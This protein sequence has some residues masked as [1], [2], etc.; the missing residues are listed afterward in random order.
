MGTQLP[1]SKKG[2]QPPFFG[3]CLLW[4]NGWMDQDATWYGGRP[5]PRPHCARR[6]PSPPPKRRG[7]QIPTI[8]FVVGKRLDGL[9]EMIGLGLDNIVLP[10]EP[11]QPPK[12]HVYCGQT[13]VH[14]SYCMLSTGSKWWPSAISDSYLLKKII[15]YTVSTG[16]G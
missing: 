7:W 12:G 13:V 10:C 2:A 8:I 11:A 14:L 6:G 15:F 4:P 5:R 16:W 3:P 9:D 1:L